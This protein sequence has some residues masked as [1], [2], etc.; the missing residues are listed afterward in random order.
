MKVQNQ[1]VQSLLN[2]LYISEIFGATIQGEGKRIGKVSIFI[3]VA[4]CNMSCS[5]F[6]VEY[7]VDGITKMGCDSFYAVD[8]GLKKNWSSLLAVDII[9]KINTLTKLKKVDIVI[10]GGEPLLY[11]QNIQFQ[12]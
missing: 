8:K 4:R 1:K 9:N 6:G 5:G 3:R 2:N 12:N 10:T 7:K 11:W